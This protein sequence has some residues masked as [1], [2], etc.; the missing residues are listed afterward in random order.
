M[1]Q[2][3]ATTIAL[4]PCRQEVWHG[5]RAIFCAAWE[6]LQVAANNAT[7]MQH[8]LGSRVQSGVHSCHM[9]LAHWCSMHTAAGK[10]KHWPTTP[11][12]HRHQQYHA[13]AQGEHCILHVL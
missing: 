5:S 7:G 4:T 10:P 1:Q 2:K 12:H 8:F 3:A 11:T 13:L 6:E 9:A